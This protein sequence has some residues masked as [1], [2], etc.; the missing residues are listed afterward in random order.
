M[1]AVTWTQVA[2]YIIMIVSFLG[3]VA[4]MGWHQHHDPVPQLSTGRL[5]Q[6]IDKEERRIVHDAAEQGVREHFLGEAQ[7]LQDRIA[8]LPQSFDDTRE[9]LNAELKLARERN[10][11][12]REI[13]ALERE[14]EAFPADASA[15]AILWNQQREEALARSRIPPPSTEPFP[16]ASEAERGTQRLNFVLLV[17]CLMVG[18]AS[19]PHILTRFHTTPSVRETRNSVGWTLF[20][21]VLLY[22]SAPALAALVKL[23]LLQHL[24][25][26]SFG[27]LPQWVVPWRK[28]DPPVFA[29]RDINGDGIVQWAEV[30]MQPDMVVLAAP[31]IAGLPYVLSGLIA[32]GALAAALS[33]ADGLL[34]TIANA[35]SHDVY[36]HMIDNTA[37]HQRRVTGAKVVLLGVALLAAY[38]TSLKPGN[39]L[40]LVG[41]AFSLAASCFFPVLVLGVFWKRTNRA[42]AIAGMLTGLAV[43][44]YYIFV[45]YPFFTRMTGILGHPWFG[46]D[47]IASG[48]FGVPAGFA[49]AIVVSLLTRPNRPV[50]DKLVGYLRDPL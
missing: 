25:G 17:F 18:T 1:R 48:A 14:R 47:P 37:S 36:F 13:K 15:A 44:V 23:D 9:S 24:V 43:S 11:P 46:V 7:A 45:N 6:Q 19:L 39:I 34:L 30:M 29:L 41:A 42:G 33:T 50:V 38:V 26:A 32:A 22:V 5:L 12:L 28:V 16:S 3:V 2:Q 10:A 20:F 40:F 49:A 21:I 27:D 8:A 4:L 31:E 35:L